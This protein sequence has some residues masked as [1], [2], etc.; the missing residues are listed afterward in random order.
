[1]TSSIGSDVFKRILVPVDFSEGSNRAFEYALLVARAF[2]AR[3]TLLHVFDRRL[4]E[5]VFNLH[6]LDRD[7]ARR[8]LDERAE[9]GFAK[10]QERATA[11]GIESER[12]VREGIPAREIVRAAGDDH[13][14]LV[15]I[16][17]H[18]TTALRDVLYGTTAEGVVR[19]A[20]CPVL[21]VGDGFG[22][23]AD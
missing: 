9:I 11:D 17:S 20:P 12:L 14:D 18:G 8:R 21:S 1:M 23:T 19:G 7:E 13:A 16:G 4:V 15:V 10:L 3:L 5:D 22:P 6:H 2:G